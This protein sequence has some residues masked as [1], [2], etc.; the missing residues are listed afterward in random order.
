M[1]MPQAMGVTTNR[2]HLAT[3]RRPTLLRR[4]WDNRY[5]VVLFLPGI[6]YFIVF[7]YIPIYGLQIAFKDYNLFEGIW[8]SP[9]TGLAVFRELFAAPSFW[10]VFLNTII[11]SALQFLF[12]FPAPIIFALLL[13]EVMNLRAKKVFQT[14]SY[15]PH[16]MSW[17]ILGGIFTQFLSPS[18]GPINLAIKAMGGRPIYFLADPSWFR[19]VLVVT[20]IW[21]GIGWG[22]IVYLA[23]LASVNPELYEA[24]QMDGAGRWRKMA[25]V[26]IPSLYPII[27]IMLILAV[28]KLVNDNFDQVYNLY[29][30]AVYSVGDVLETYMYRKGLAD[31]MYSYATAVGLFKNLLAFTLVI[32]ANRI[33]KS[34]NEYGIW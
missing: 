16:F 28:G 26:T 10:E 11:L 7:R 23:S 29:N 4:Y 5:L 34:V 2:P 20:E 21:K 12:G 22:S 33:A 9:W 19:Q 14:V 27:T 30:P 1:A 17:V 6:L 15:L 32:V 8:K 18:I 13:N 31:M 24:A 25:S 3:V